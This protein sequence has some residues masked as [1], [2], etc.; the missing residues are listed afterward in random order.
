MYALRTADLPLAGC[1]SKKGDGDG[2]A[3]AGLGGLAINF[4]ENGLDLSLRQFTPKP[5]EA[6]LPPTKSVLDTPKG[7][8][9]AKTT[10]SIGS[11]TQSQPSS[12]QR[13]RLVKSPKEYHASSK[14]NTDKQTCNDLLRQLRDSDKHHIHYTEDY[15]DPLIQQEP[16]IPPQQ[17]QKSEVVSRKIQSEGDVPKDTDPSV[18]PVVSANGAAHELPQSEPYKLQ[19]PQHGTVLDYQDARSDIKP[20]SKFKRGLARVKSI[21]ATLKGSGRTNRDSQP[22]T[23]KSCKVKTYE[24]SAV[25]D[26]QS[27]SNDSESLGREN[28]PAKPDNVETPQQ[29][30]HGQV[31]KRITTPQLEGFLT[32]EAIQHDLVRFANAFR[33]RVAERQQMQPQQNSENSSSAASS[34]AIRGGSGGG[35]RG[36]GGMPPWMQDMNERIRY[37]REDPEFQPFRRNYE[38]HLDDGSTEY[39][40]EIDYN[41]ARDGAIGPQGQ[42]GRQDDRRGGRQGDRQGGRR[43]GGLGGGLRDLF[44]GRPRSPPG[45]FRDPTDML[46]PGRGQPG[47]GHPGMGH[48][49]MGYPGIGYPGMAPMGM[50]H[51][52]M[53]PPGMGGQMAMGQPGMGGFGMMPPGMAYPGMRG[54]GMFPGGAGDEDKDDRPGAEAEDLDLDEARFRRRLRVAEMFNDAEYAA[55]LTA[56][57]AAQLNRNR[58]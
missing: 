16:N 14:R 36:L 40:E 48:P 37:I 26:G 41:S 45:G 54:Y 53:G 49:G 6:H 50:R 17:E 52:G 19:D 47:M 4:E 31:P 29:A 56:Q 33:S 55:H 13:K 5:A 35:N 51:P 44:G 57:R 21:S 9:R 15:P 34:S 8:A 38:N 32:D 11:S 2:A 20:K 25:K 39:V 30:A 42:G 22:E 7:D 18:S 43:G 28:G 24:E 46:F 1:S 12:R 27:I 10:M 23:I 3:S 58:H